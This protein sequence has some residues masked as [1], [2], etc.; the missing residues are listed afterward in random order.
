ME[1]GPAVSI[2]TSPTHPYTRALLEAAP[3]PDPDEQRRRRARRLRSRS[4]DF[5]L[6]ADNGCP[7]APRC[8]HALDPCWGVRPSLET[9]RDGSLVACHFWRELQASQVAGTADLSRA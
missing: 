9:N 3:V 5:A 7:F 6:R 8:P 2:Y 4:A 1:Q